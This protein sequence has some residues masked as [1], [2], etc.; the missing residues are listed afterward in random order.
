MRE[1]FAILTM[2]IYISI[3][4][5]YSFQTR[6]NLKMSTRSE[7]KFPIMVNGMPGP[8]AVETAKACIDRGLW[9]LPVGFTGPAQPSQITVVGENISM[10]VKLHSGPGLSDNANEILRDLKREHP[11]LIIIDYTHPSAILNNLKA[12]VD[13]S[14]DFVMGTTGGDPSEMSAIL[15]SGSNYAIIAPNM[16]KQIVAIQ[17]AL[18]EM[19]KRFP[20]SFTDY[21]LSVEESHQSSKADT[22]GTA[23]AIVTQLNVL[24][25]DPSFTFDQIEK[26]RIMD[27]QLEFGVPE[28]AL[29]GHAF[30]T[31]V[32]RSKDGSTAFQLQ[33]NVCGRRIYAEGTTDAVEFLNKV[34]SGKPDKRIYN[35]IDVLEG[36]AMR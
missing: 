5:Q 8:M 11:N 36:G 28:S 34:R 16:A 21:T 23:K 29:K 31:Y 27:K 17:A 32:L 1:L 10:D 3:S 33:H 20:S 35:M 26:I 22:S 9:V 7:E 6:Y 12:Y 19:A 14:C 15:N 4:M 13:N 18:Q 30:H 25:G 2:A 24:T